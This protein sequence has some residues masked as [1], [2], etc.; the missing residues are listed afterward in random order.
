MRILF[1][2]SDFPDATDFLRQRLPRDAGDEIVVWSRGDMRSMLPGVDVVIPKMQRID[3]D[4]MQSGSFRLIQQWGAGLEGI[5]LN[6][7]RA[8]KIWVSNVPAASNAESVAEHTILLILCLLRNLPLAQSNVRS[9]ILGAP[10]GNTLARRTVCL[11]G[12]GAIALALAKR[13]SSFGVRLIGIT[14]DPTSPKVAKFGLQRCFGVSERDR[15]LA[16]ADILVLCVRYSEEMRDTIGAH[17]LAC[18]PR[19]AYLV[20]VA[21]GG[22]VNYKALH[23]ALI[24]KQIAG[25]AM[26]VFWEEPIAVNDPM[27]TLPNVIATPH[28]GGI[29][30]SS[31]TD[32]A[33]AVVANIE[34]LRKGEPP[35]NQAA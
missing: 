16:E 17:E 8:L 10:L 21:R 3:R 9:G 29:T 26:D 6:S 13:L 34:R 30:R 5:D 31:F 25:A 23:A 27:L 35:L 33:D 11:Y 4:L 14:R 28:I 32:I 19:G 22:L 24:S 20:N 2:G 7:A 15:C 18:L 1:C 12:L